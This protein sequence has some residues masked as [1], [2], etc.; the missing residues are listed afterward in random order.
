M[1]NKQDSPAN[2]EREPSVG[3]FIGKVLEFKYYTI[4]R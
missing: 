4:W 3:K 2:V 1:I